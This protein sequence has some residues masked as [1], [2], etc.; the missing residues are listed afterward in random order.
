MGI[1]S[2]GG[3]AALY[4]TF[5]QSNLNNQQVQYA[6]VRIPTAQILTMRAT[7]V[8]LVPAPGAGFAI[9]MIRTLVHLTFGGTAFAGTGTACAL[10][11]G[12][13]AGGVTV[14]TLD[15]LVKSAANAAQMLTGGVSA[16]PA[17]TALVNQPL[18]LANN[19]TVEYTTGNGS[20]LVEVFYA[21]VPVS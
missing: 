12:P 10:F 16:T 17:D 1:P 2:G 21:V 14:G 4:A 15:A 6:A 5:A 3:S 11:W 7:P 20:L 13:P 18:Q 9:V 19:G 8:V